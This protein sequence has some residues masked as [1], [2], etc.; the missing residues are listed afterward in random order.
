[1]NDYR[2]ADHPRGTDGRYVRKTTGGDDADLDDGNMVPEPIRRVVDSGRTVLL[3]PGAPKTELEYAAEHGSYRTKCNIAL[4]SDAGR[5]GEETS[6][7]L[8]DDLLAPVDR[9]AAYHAVSGLNLS[10]SMMT[11]MAGS[12]DPRLREALAR[13]PHLPDRARRRLIHDSDA[14]VRRALAWHAS[15]VEAHMLAGDPSPMV[16][17]AVAANPN[18]P[19]VDLD[20]LASDPAE[21]VRCAVAGNAGT[22]A[23]TLSRLAGDPALSV[24]LQVVSNDRTPRETVE[25]VDDR[26]LARERARALYARDHGM[27][28]AMT[29]KYVSSGDLRR[30]VSESLNSGGKH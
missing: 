17:E 7:R 14:R 22:P 1:M 16:R 4:S 5:L 26:K 21:P 24:R 6:D 25:R 2:E 20:A 27:T 3:A 29:F 28:Y 9:G 11:N 19:V 30:A 18:T 15:G 8:L 12:P 23:G 13:R 10:E